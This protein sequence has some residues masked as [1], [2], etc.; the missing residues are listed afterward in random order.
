MNAFTDTHTDV[1]MYCIVYSICTV[2]TDVLYIYMSSYIS[3]H[4]SEICELEGL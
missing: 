1:C 3:T 2:G 4:Q